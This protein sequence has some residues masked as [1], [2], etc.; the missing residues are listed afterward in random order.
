MTNIN[1]TLI[2][3]NERLDA[4][5]D[6]V[7]DIWTALT[8]LTKPL[9]RIGWNAAADRLKES[10]T[11][12]IDVT[13]LEEIRKLIQ[14]ELRHTSR[15]GFAAMKEDMERLN[16]ICLEQ[17]SRLGA[18][19]MRICELEAY[20]DDKPRDDNDAQLQDVYPDDWQ[21]GK[22]VNRDPSDHSEERAKDEVGFEEDDIE[23]KTKMSAFV[24]KG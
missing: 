19:Q 20:A 10:K 23:M 5:V 15:P 11:P 9:E 22:G 13:E 12:N 2:N 17:N 14:D 7:Q 3:T 21:S 8:K 4:L 24:P 18:L 16:N 1:D 6:A